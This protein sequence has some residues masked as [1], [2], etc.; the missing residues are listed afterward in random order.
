MTQ[1]TDTNEGLPTRANVLLS[2]QR[3]LLGRV[4]PA[5][6]AV[7]VQI[8]A[9]E[10]CAR[11]YFDGSISEADQEEMSDA[12]AEVLAD[13]RPEVVVHFECVRLDGPHRISDENTWAYARKEAAD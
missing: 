6:R 11:C 2:V 9:R 4:M 12:E 10:V 3:A 1:P 8:G 7:V 13:Y 5:L